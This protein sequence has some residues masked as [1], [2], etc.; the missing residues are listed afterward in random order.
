MLMTVAH[1]TASKSLLHAEM[2]SS[3]LEPTP[4]VSDTRKVITCV[5]VNLFNA[6]RLDALC[7]NLLANQSRISPRNQMAVFCTLVVKLNVLLNLLLPHVLLA[8]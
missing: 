1:L 6:L 7:L 5:V 3:L 2:V 8:K 4:A